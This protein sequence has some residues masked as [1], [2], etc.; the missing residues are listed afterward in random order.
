[1]QAKQDYLPAV[2]HVVSLLHESTVQRLVRIECNT[3]F[4]KEKNINKHKKRKK[5]LTSIC[6]RAFGKDRNSLPLLV[7]PEN[8]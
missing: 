7:L 3:T 1:M 8:I 4:R 5:K 2:L 6:P